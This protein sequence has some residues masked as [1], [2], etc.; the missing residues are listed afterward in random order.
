MGAKT[1]YSFGHLDRVLKPEG[2]G[3]VYGR[4]RQSNHMGIR[5]ECFH[6]RQD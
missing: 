5:A 2:A 6:G 4:Y 1:K 3:G